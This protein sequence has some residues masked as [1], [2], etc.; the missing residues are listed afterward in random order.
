MELRD[1]LSEHQISKNKEDLKVYG[2]DWNPHYEPKPSFVVFVEN[3]EQVEKLISYA[4]EKNTALVPQ[5]DE[6]V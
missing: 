3:S 5:G 6:P 2:K 4:K 1:F